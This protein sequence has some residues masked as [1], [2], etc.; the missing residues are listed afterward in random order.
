MANYKIGNFTETVLF[1]R[2]SFEITATGE[3]DDNYVLDS[4]RLCEIQDAVDKA[5]TI[6]DALAATQSYSV[7]TWK[8]E[9]ITTEWQ[10]E[11]NGERYYIDRILNEERD[12]SRYEIRKIDLCS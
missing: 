9:G 4:E 1:L 7:V 6:A 2:P 12:I 11:Y 3:R 5:E 8:V 10:A